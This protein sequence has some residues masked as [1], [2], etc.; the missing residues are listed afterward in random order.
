MRFRR[1]AQDAACPVVR[2]SPKKPA[3]SPSRPTTLEYN[4]DTEIVT[5]AGNVV[6]R[7]AGQSV[8]ADSV[9][10]NRTTN[11]ITAKGNIR[12]VDKD[13]NVLY[14][15]TLTLTD[16]LKIGAMTNLLLALREGGRLRGQHRRSAR[17]T[18]PSCSTTQPIRPAQWK[19]TR[20]APRRPAGA[21]IAEQVVYDP[22]QR[23]ASASRARTLEL[24]GIRLRAAAGPRRS[25]PTGEAISGLARFRTSATRPR[26]ASKSADGYYW[27]LG[28]NQDLTVAGYVYTEAPPMVSAQYRALTGDG[29]FQ[30]DRLC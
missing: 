4:Y 27:R 19:T 18:A 11:D 9:A 15:D 6:L 16:D 7:S 28:D 2:R 13:G 3:R 12:F 5:A 1:S 23:S 22:D 30:V 10:W 14:T 20:A 21:C 8:R 26:T 17:R 29:A 25:R 24:F